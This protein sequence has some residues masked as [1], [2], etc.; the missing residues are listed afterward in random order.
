MTAKFCLY[1]SSFVS[2]KPM[3][4]KTHGFTYLCGLFWTFRKYSRRIP[5]KLKQV[6]PKTQANLLKTQ[7]FA[8]WKPNF[9]RHLFILWQKNS[10][11]S[12]KL[13]NFQK[14][15]VSKINSRNFRKNLKVLP[16][17]DGL[18]CGKMSK[19]AWLMVHY[20]CVIWD[21]SFNPR[22]ISKLIAYLE[23]SV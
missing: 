14:I 1:F 8:N 16:T 19:K 17:S 9:F 4:L 12:T 11:F 15:E 3:S 20:F 5:K 6:S 10:I 22:G 7:E 13:T 18:S 2:F 23:S 21:I